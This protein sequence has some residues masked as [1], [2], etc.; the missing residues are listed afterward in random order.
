VDG[1]CYGGTIAEDC[2]DEAVNDGVNDRYRYRQAE[3]TS[4]LG[5][6]SCIARNDVPVKGVA[7]DTVASGAS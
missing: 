7:Q 4:F 6:K 1:C 2:G 3:E 5:C